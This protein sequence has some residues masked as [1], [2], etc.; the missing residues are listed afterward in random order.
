M[1][2]INFVGRPSSYRWHQAICIRK[3]SPPGSYAEVYMSSRDQDEIF[4][5]LP[6]RD[7]SF[8]VVRE[9]PAGLSANLASLEE[10]KHFVETLVSVE[11][12]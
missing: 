4:Q 10:A 2:R 5:I 6:C 1:T 12:S 8:D 3:A 7:G 11:Y 9:F